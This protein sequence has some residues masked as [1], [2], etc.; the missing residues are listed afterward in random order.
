MFYILNSSI[1][2]SF[3]M[4]LYFCFESSEYSELLLSKILHNLLDY[5][6]YYYTV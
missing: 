5:L 3:I 2:L 4:I 6:L 1:K